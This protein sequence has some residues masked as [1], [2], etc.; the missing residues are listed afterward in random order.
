MRRTVQMLKTELSSPVATRWGGR[1]EVDPEIWDYANSLTATW[2]RR[3]EALLL[4][5]K[6]A[7]PYELH[8]DTKGAQGHPQGIDLNGASL[9]FSESDSTLQ[10]MIEHN[11]RIL[12][13]A[14]IADQENAYIASIRFSCCMEDG[15]YYEDIGNADLALITKRI[16]EGRKG[17]LE[18]QA[19][20]R[21]LIGKA[22]TQCNIPT[23]ISPTAD[24]GLD[25]PGLQPRE[26]ARIIQLIDQVSQTPDL[27][28]TAGR[29]DAYQPTDCFGFRAFK[30]PGHPQGMER[31]IIGH[32]DNLAISLVADVPPPPAHSAT[33]LRF[34]RA[35]FDT[36]DAKHLASHLS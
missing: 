11:S 8:A 12:L 29:G 32:C 5:L 21:K 31:W 2:F 10:F 15:N 6:G 25:I 13:V 7:H 36:P 19:E 24:I 26:I 28:R 20:L 4:S 3:L 34:I 35:R 27:T 30:L 33:I 14:V 1:L 9:F 23:A 16:Q 17:A 18:S 22:R